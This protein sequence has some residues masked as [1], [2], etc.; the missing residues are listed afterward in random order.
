MNPSIWIGHRRVAVAQHPDP[1]N[2][3]HLFFV[4]EKFAFRGGE[5]IRLV[6]RET[7]SPCRIETILLLPTLPRTLKPRLTLSTPDVD[8]RHE[9]DHLFAYASWITN[10]PASGTFRWGKVGARFK[11]VRIRNRSAHESSMDALEPGLTYRYEIDLRAGELH[12]T[13]AGSFTP[14]ARGRRR[15]RQEGRFTLQDVRATRIPWPISMGMPFPQG[16]VTDPRTIRLL[17]QNDNEAIPSQVRPL[18]HWPDGSIRWLL[19]DFT[20]DGSEGVAVEYGHR[21]DPSDSVAGIHTQNRRAEYV[22]TT[23]PLR[24]RF[25]KDRTVLPGLVERFDR[26]TNTY[27][28][29]T[30]P[31]GSPAVSLYDGRG[32][33]F[34]SLKPDIV[35]I[36][37][38]GSE[39]VC[40]RIDVPHR[41]RTG[42]T[43]FSSTFRVHLY[44]NSTHI[45]IH[46]TYLNDADDDFTRV[47]RLT[48]RVDT[49]FG[50]SASVRS[51][52]QKSSLTD[53]PVSLTQTHDDRFVLSQKNATIKEGRH[54]AL[55]ITRF[56]CRL[57]SGRGEGGLRV[58]RRV[59]L[60][61]GKTIPRGGRSTRGVSQ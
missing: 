54:E 6:T 14:R 59:V 33:V 51:E 15:A 52:G 48:L 36:E 24:V 53:G 20:S 58:S 10:R 56:C 13:H 31:K 9:G 49:P 45:K 44:R 3:R 42:D 21:I 18:S 8:V 27:L 12:A 5:R 46:H 16:A 60:G 28:P 32:R 29:I 25:P 57:A 40:V 17:D 37:E 55:R 43:L 22:V 26:K 1:D 19:T 23:G 47:R 2:R 30:P 11:T 38:S 34:N 35:R 39:R 61:S 41:N 7:D 50:K 4:P